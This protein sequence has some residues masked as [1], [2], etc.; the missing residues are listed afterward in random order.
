[1]IK[2]TLWRILGRVRKQDL[3]AH[4]ML[5]AQHS[6]ASGSKDST[7]SHKSNHELEVFSHQKCGT[8]GLLMRA[9]SWLPPSP[10]TVYSKVNQFHLLENESKDPMLKQNH[11]HSRPTYYNFDFTFLSL[12]QFQQKYHLQ[13]PFTT[14]YG[15][16]NS[17]PSRWRCMLKTMDLSNPSEKSSQ[18]PPPKNITS[19]SANVAILDH[20]SKRRNK[21]FTLRFY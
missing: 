10:G 3:K 21:N 20:S 9:C 17:I 14:Y 8:D 2:K 12:D 15:L 19:H 13:V 18:K 5:S 16:I 6:M 7:L 1:M 4:F 11:M